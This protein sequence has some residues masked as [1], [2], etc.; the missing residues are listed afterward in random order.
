MSGQS[1]LPVTQV[2]GLTQRELY[3]KSDRRIVTDIVYDLVRVIDAAIQTAHSSGFC[4]IEHELPTNFGINNMN[5]TDAQTMIYSELLM[6]YSNP[7]SEGG[8]GFSDC[9][10][11]IGIKTILKIKW[12]NGIDDAERIRRKSIIASRTAPVLL[13]QK[14]KKL[15]IK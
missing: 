5:K 3:A 2:R 8:K 15:N 7:E 4:Y 11:D 12:L 6:L 13:A 14:Q 1:Q 10:I 9:T